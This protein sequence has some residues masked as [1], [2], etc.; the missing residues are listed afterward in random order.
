MD[1]WETLAALR[2]LAPGIPVILASGY[3]QA[4]VMV[5]DHPERPQDFLSKPYRL[6]ELGK[7]VHH[8]LADKPDG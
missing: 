5:G 2:R 3:D 1:G 8:A 7:A 4:Q 6:A